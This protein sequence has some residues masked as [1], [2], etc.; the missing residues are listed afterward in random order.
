MKTRLFT[1]LFATFAIQATAA[2]PIPP[3]L[4]GEWR[5]PDG[6]GILY[7][8]AD[9]FGAVV[10]GPPPIGVSFLA[11]YDPKDSTI[12]LKLRVSP[13][14]LPKGAPHPPDVKLSYDPKALAIKSN[15]GSGV[16]YARHSERLPK[17][18][19]PLEQRAPW[20]QEWA[21]AWD[22]GTGEG[23][24]AEK[25]IGHVVEAIRLSPKDN[26][27]LG[28]LWDYLG[29]LYIDRKVYDSAE[30]A[31]KTHLSLIQAQ[32]DP[33]PRELLSVYNA[34]GVLYDKSGNIEGRKE[35]L[36][37]AIA[38]NRSI[39][40]GDSAQEAECW[41]RLAEITHSSGNSKEAAAMLDRAIQMYS[42]VK[43]KI[44]PVD[45]L[46]RKLKKWRTE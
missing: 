9:G 41:Q 29:R 21:K 25:A 19:T 20:E 5:T 22:I 37:N 17:E 24:D 14:E 26:E 11:T 31:F 16:S 13:R 1:F 45:Y 18:F 43:D 30:S 36:R 23:T 34:L 27:K 35:A 44:A 3:D 7:F 28:T 40:G 2:N 32:P 39:Y 33:K 15:D 6:N 42:S 38:L 4:I 12:T 10:G 8:R 46:R